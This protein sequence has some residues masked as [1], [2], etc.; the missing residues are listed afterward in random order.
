MF[1]NLILSRPLAV[2]DL[3]TT[4]INPLFDRI[5]EIS[6]LKVSPDAPPDH[7]TRRLNPGV[8]IPLEAQAIHGIGDADVAHEPEFRDVA[9]GLRELLDGCDL[10]GFNLKRFD[11]P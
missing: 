3:E 7:R 4:G 10:C 2:I 8:P 6:V 11:L 5:V 9:G 1:K